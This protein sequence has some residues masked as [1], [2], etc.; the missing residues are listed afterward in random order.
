MTDIYTFTE[1]P[2]PFDVYDLNHLVYDFI[3]NNRPLAT[4]NKYTIY[5]PSKGRPS[6]N[7][8]AGLLKTLR[9]KIVV[10]PQ[11]YGRYRAIYPAENLVCLEENN[12]GLAYVRNYIKTYS[13]ACGE[14]HHWQIDDDVI[15]FKVRKLH[16]TKNTIVDP[17]LAISIV[18]HCMDMFSNVAISGI[19][20]DAFAFSK[21]YP[22]QVNRLAY[23]CVLVDNTVPVDWT[24][25]GVEDWHYMFDVLERGYCTLAFHHIMTNTSPTMQTSGGSTDIHFAGDKRKLLY[26]EFINRW[27]NRFMLKEYPN[28][29]KRWRLQPIRKFFGDYKQNLILKNNVSTIL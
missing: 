22:V 28:S 20:S 26:Q 1:Q 23:Q 8:T 12:K 16:H 7:R 27:P 6:T 10:E 4:V 19:G 13:R 9:Y 29:K 24:M 14:T 5:I 2:K 21:K 18:E 15:H 25:G 3:E 17:L 11:D